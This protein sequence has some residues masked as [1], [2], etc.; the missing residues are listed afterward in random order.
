MPVLN[1]LL[2]ATDPLASLREGGL[3][4]SLAQRA[5]G[6]LGLATILGLAWLL[7]YD[8]KRVPWRLVGMGLLLQAS[9]GLLVLK[10]TPGRWFFERVGV[11]PVRRRVPPR[12]AYAGAGL[13]ELTWNVLRLSGEPPMTRFLA[14]QLATS[15]SYDPRPAETDFGYRERVDM[16]E[17]TDRLVASLDGDPGVSG[18]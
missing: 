7:S 1:L 13:L 2:S 8:R 18:V 12:V 14:S 3:D 4:L 6:L 11:A 15:H 17:A 16:R 9:F 10:S 5:T